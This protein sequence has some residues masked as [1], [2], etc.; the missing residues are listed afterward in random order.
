MCAYEL[1]VLQLIPFKGST[2]IVR[3]IS[4]TSVNH[5]G[6]RPVL[7]IAARVRLFAAII[8]SNPA[9]YLR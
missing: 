3:Y 1:Q 6:A 7:I 8:G 4:Y 2:Q 9:Y 5:I